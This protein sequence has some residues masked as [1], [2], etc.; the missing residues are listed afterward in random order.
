MPKGGLLDLVAHGVQD[1]YLIGNP[2][3]SFF[4]KV[5]KRHTNFVTESIRGTFNGS[6]D[7]GEK[8][9]LN[10]PRNGDLVNTIIMEVDLPELE[11]TGSDNV[12]SIQYISNVGQALLEYSELKIGGQTIDKQ[13]SEWVYIW[14]QL[15]LGSPKLREYNEMIKSTAQ[16]GPMTVYVPFYFWFC[17]DVANSLPL[18][19]LQYHDVELEIKLR[20]LSELYNFG[21]RQYYDFEYLGTEIYLGTTQYKYRKTNG[22]LFTPDVDGKLYV[23]NNGN[24]SAN[25]TYIDET[26]TIYLDTELPTSGLTRG[27]VKPTYTLSNN[28]SISDIRIYIDYIYLDTF[29]RS[30]FAKE[31]HRYLI[32]QTQYSEPIGI[33]S[34]ET[35]KKIELDFNLP[36]KE[37]FWVCQNDELI[38][39][40]EQLKFTSSPDTIYENNTDDLTNIV[41][42]YNGNERFEPRQGEYFRLIQPHQKHRQSVYDKYIY[43]YSMAMNPEKHQPSGASNFSKIDKVE[44]VSNLRIN[45]PYNS[46]IKIFALNYN[47]LRVSQGMGGVAFGN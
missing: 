41:L 39:N 5:Y 13:Y 17:R 45:R 24:Q 16:N 32:E 14:S 28:P 15:T 19:A 12:H 23:Y 4:K 10:I 34:S 9:V 46:K 18:V 1:V 44:F 42:L 6:P 11:A 3:Y 22:A 8:I 38:D 29:E 20:P 26:D 43:V 47:I 36:V 35:T 21:D 37:L 31:E 25:I 2:N 7:F 27:Y 40:N 30:Y 33:I